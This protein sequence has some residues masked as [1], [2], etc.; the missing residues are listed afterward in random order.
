MSAPKPIQIIGGGLAGLTLGIAL[1][2]NNSDQAI[3]LEPCFHKFLYSNDADWQISTAMQ[4]KSRT[5]PF[6]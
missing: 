5:K 6:G 3:I 2:R 4:L 1:S